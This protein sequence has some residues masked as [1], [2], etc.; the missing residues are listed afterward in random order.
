MFIWILLSVIFL[1][2]WNILPVFL[3]FP[4]IGPSSSSNSIHAQLSAAPGPRGNSASIWV[5]SA[6]CLCKRQSLLWAETCPHPGHK[7]LQ[8][9]SGHW[10]I[11]GNTPPYTSGL[12]WTNRSDLWV[13]TE[14]HLPTSSTIFKIQ[15][16]GNTY[17]CTTETMVVPLILHFVPKVC[18]LP[19]MDL[20]AL[21]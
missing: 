1:Y 9:P 10:Q 5:H 20:Q 11:D 19:V 21:D 16:S 17:S 7:I 2:C 4:S 18:I 15:Q 13:L 14:N 3:R 8:R 6:T 12:L